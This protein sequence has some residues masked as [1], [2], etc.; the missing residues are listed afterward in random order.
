MASIHITS[1]ARRY[2]TVHG[3]VEEDTEL[4]LKLLATVPPSLAFHFE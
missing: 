1:V 3:V 4:V 2:E